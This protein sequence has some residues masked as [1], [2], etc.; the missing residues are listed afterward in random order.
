[1]ARGHVWL[2]SGYVRHVTALADMATSVIDAKK[3]IAK[4]LPSL[5]PAVPRET[6]KI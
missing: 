6:H 1:M 3:D 5:V 2:C 4:R